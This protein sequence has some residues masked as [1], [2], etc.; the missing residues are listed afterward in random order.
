MCYGQTG[1]GKTHTM[2]GNVAAQ[3]NQGIIPQALAHI[4]RIMAN[5]PDRHTSIRFDNSLRL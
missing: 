5:T 2:T 3:G 1:S 4:F